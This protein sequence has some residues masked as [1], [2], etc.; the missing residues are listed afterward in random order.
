MANSNGFL[1]AYVG[2]WR[3]FWHCYLPYCVGQSHLGYNEMACRTVSCVTIGSCPVVTSRFGTACREALAGRLLFNVSC[4]ARSLLGSSS[5]GQSCIRHESL[6]VTLCFSID[7]RCLGGWSARWREQAPVLRSR[8]RVDLRFSARLFFLI[9]VS[10]ANQ[11]M[12]VSP[13]I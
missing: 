12:H 5:G 7:V 2:D 11:D 1:V 10:Q 13:F 8:L 9:Y 6:L 3:E 4:V